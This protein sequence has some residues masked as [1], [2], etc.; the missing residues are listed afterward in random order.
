MVYG[1]DAGIMPH[2]QAGR[3]FATMVRWGMP[4]L[5]AIR[6]ATRNAAQALG[7]DKDVGTI[8]VGR[9]GDLVAVSGDPLA[10]VSVLERPNAVIKGGK[11][12]KGE[13]TAPRP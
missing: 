13:G 2:G 5:E 4:P 11:L 9:F 8:E 3:Q 1:T 10:D 7:R 6:A 12:V